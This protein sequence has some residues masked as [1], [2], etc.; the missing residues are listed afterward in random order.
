MMKTTPKIP[1]LAV[2]VLATIGIASAATFPKEG[3]YDYTSC[4]S[5]ST[6]LIAFSKTHN[7]F[8][9]EMMGVVVSKV[10]GSIFD[11]NTFRC[12]GLATSFAGKPGGANVCEA[13]DGDGDKRLSSFSMAADGQFTREFI[14]GTGKYEGMTMTTNVTRMGPFPTIKAGTFQECN[15]QTGTYKLK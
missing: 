9:Y 12:V 14:G 3:A 11:N 13:I 1:L 8:T 7:A 5:G 15:H 10:P 4:W 2:A 6:Q